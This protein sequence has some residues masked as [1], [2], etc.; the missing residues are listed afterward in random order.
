MLLRTAIVES[1]S[2][3]PGGTVP[4][5]GNVRAWRIPGPVA[6]A[7]VTTFPELVHIF[8]TD[9]AAAVL[10]DCGRADFRLPR[11][12]ASG[13]GRRP[14]NEQRP[15]R[16][17]RIAGRS[18][19]TRFTSG[20]SGRRDDRS[21]PPPGKARS[22]TTKA[23][24][25]GSATDKRVATTGRRR[26]AGADAGQIAGGAGGGAGHVAAPSRCRR[27]HRV[28][29][30]RHPQVA[31]GGPGRR[32]QGDGGG[33][34]RVEV[35]LEDVEARRAEQRPERPR[36]TPSPPE[37]GP[38]PGNAIIPLADLEALFTRVREAEGR[39]VEAAARHQAAEA[40]VRH[41]AGEVAE[42]RR[43]LQAAAAETT[44]ARAAVEERATVPPPATA[45]VARVTPAAPAAP[46]AT[47]HRPPSARPTA[48]GGP[49]TG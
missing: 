22:L 36:T 45:R 6:A 11:P 12:T 16:G 43:Q 18:N 29:R 1:A 48:P 49:S 42:L 20:R 47:D 19:C 32:P 24:T 4:A 39:C 9:H 27:P 3:A 38:P 15:G 7:F 17:R 40:D 30:Q 13:L 44:T 46:A 10:P 14:P 28:L 33:S 2:A 37:A 8:P 35:R 21:G 34:E 23:T 25:T 5:H 26:D 41:L 31:A